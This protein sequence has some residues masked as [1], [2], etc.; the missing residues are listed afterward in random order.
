MATATHCE[1][2]RA[3]RRLHRSGDDSYS[4]GA[5]AAVLSL[6]AGGRMIAA[7]K[8]IERV[9]FLVGASRLHLAGVHCLNIGAKDENCLGLNDDMTM[10]QRRRSRYAPNNQI[11]LAAEFALKYGLRLVLGADG[12]VE[13]KGTLDGEAS[14]GEES[15]E[16]ALEAWKRASGDG[17]ARR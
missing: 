15:A 17:A 2:A 9:G 10:T 16:A 11:D 13:I 3:I 6:H 1:P 14:V 5:H 8:Q 4:I 7:P 12:S